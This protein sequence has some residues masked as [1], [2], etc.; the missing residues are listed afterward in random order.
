MVQVR[1]HFHINAAGDINLQRWLQEL[2]LE[3]GEAD[4][5][6]LLRACERAQE[7]RGAQGID[8]GDWALESDC[9]LAGLHMALIL[10]DLHVGLDCLLA[11]IL[12]RSVREERLERARKK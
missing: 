2:P 5:T 12:Y 11:G 8:A 1:E 10:A 3:L 9:F 7:A 4:Q 6:R